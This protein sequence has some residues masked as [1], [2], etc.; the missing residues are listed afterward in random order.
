M[1]KETLLRILNS[2]QLR[3]CM[4]SCYAPESEHK[5]RHHEKIANIHRLN[6][7]RRKRKLLSV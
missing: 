6:A 7:Y 5:R 2:E 4:R 3:D 1:L